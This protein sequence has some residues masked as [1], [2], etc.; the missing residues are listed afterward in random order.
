RE[1]NDDYWE[2]GYVP[3]RSQYDNSTAHALEYYIADNALSKFAKALGKKKDAEKFYKQS[4]NYKKYYSKEYGLFRPRL[5]D[6]SFITPFDPKQ[7]EDFEDVPGF[8]EGSSWGYSFMV[9][10]DVKGL[11]KMH[12]GKKKF[13][14]K[15]QR[16]FDEDHYDPTNE[17]NIDYAYLFSYIPGEEKRTQKLTQDLLAEHFKNTP[18]GL[19]GNDDTGTMSTWAMFA[20]MG[21]YPNN[22]T[23]PYYT[24]TSPVFDKIELNLNSEYYKNNQLTIE[25]VRPNPSA[26]YIERIELDGKTLK[27]YRIDHQDLVN[28]KRLVFYMK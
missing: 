20:M 14:D 5:P 11:I 10:H 8:H 28:A 22:A 26:K 19:P 25:V 2:M 6:G 18:D 4:L 23:E 9:P 16:V 3:L 13:V 1:D 15:L 12:G 17:P 7:G 24:F 21:F 27:G